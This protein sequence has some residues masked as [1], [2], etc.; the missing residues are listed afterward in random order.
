[1]SAALAVQTLP[2]QQGAPDWI[3]LLPAGPQVQTVTGDS[4]GPFEL[5]DPAAVI[6]AS[7]ARLD[8][9]PVDE[10]HALVTAAEDGRPSPARGWITAMEAR[11]DGIW[12]KVD[13]TEVGRELVEG[14]AY[15]KLSPVVGL[16][17]EKNGRITHIS[18][19]ALTNTPAL[20]EMAGLF[21]E[22][23]NMGLMEKL[24]KLTGMEAAA[25]EEAVLAR[26]E[27]LIEAGQS[28]GEDKTEAMSAQITEIA[29][30]L[31]VKGSDHQAI[32]SAAKAVAA[33][34]QIEVVVALRAQV[35][36]LATQ[37]N[38][39]TEST[40]RTAAEAYVDAEI[41]RG[42]VGVKPLRDHYI[43]RFMKAPDEVK[44][45]LEAL[46]IL[47]G[48]GHIIT[49][50]KPDKNGKAALSAEHRQAARMLGHTEEAYA[51]TLSAERAAQEEA[52]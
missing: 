9:I 14:R 39:L 46:P 32:L 7:F 33:G 37:L 43:E 52:L 48:G 19:V 27:N 42:R 15:R 26:I 30:A 34:D 18:S 3:Q 35:T 1:M 31:G 41:K 21:M 50:A 6:A 45:E 4:R 36:E 2:K 10:N 17:A 8:Q 5:I 49:Q 11:S 13:W 28:M 22:N 23:R 38:T 25:G 44:T 24:A 29:E 40:G 20:A 16:T 47:G 12:G 51:A